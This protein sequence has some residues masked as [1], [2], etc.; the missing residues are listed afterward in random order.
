MKN[1]KI[2]MLELLHYL[3]DG[4]I[5]DI[6]Y[7]SIVYRYDKIRECYKDENSNYLIEDFSKLT[8]K[9][10]INSEFEIVRCY[11]LN[12]EEKQLLK[13]LCK[14]NTE[15]VTNVIVKRYLYNYIVL[16]SGK[17]VVGIEYIKKGEFKNLKTDKLYDLDIIL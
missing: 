10:F 16:I 3:K 14:N 1:K 15:K 5:F 8:D 11:L 2:T 13:K 6:K 7:G 9:N 17:E 4:I 12:R